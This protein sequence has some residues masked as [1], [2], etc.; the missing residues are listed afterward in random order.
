LVDLVYGRRPPSPAPPASSPP[1]DARP[2]EGAAPASEP[3][4][5]FNVTSQTTTDDDMETPFLDATPGASAERVCF[6]QEKVDRVGWSAP[7][8]VGPGQTLAFLARSFAGTA[9][10]GFREVAEQPARLTVFRE[11]PGG[12]IVAQV[13]VAAHE[14]PRRFEVVD[15]SPGRYVIAIEGQVDKAQPPAWTQ[16]EA[17]AVG[18]GNVLSDD[19]LEAQTRVEKGVDVGE[20]VA[21]A[22]AER[23]TMGKTASFGVSIPVAVGAGQ[24]LFAAVR[25]PDTHAPIVN[26]YRWARQRTPDEVNRTCIVRLIEKQSGR[27]VAHVVADPLKDF[28]LKIVVSGVQPGAYVL[29]MSGLVD[30]TKGPVP[31]QGFAGAIAGSRETP[32][33]S[34]ATRPAS[35]QPLG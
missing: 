27:A 12:A 10:T 5:G 6:G 1:Q 3:D 24:D 16:V 29:A 7:I 28:P 21:Q 8:N 35:I 25:F 19:A 34:A 15:L 33:A 2:S 13:T 14:L 23:V 30:R 26:Q 32:G 4:D 17:W 22:T 31:M 20:L 18:Q 9:Y 11:R